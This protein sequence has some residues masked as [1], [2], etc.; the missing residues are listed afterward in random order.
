MLIYV[1]KLYN[2]K[3][4]NLFAGGSGSAEKRLWDWLKLAEDKNFKRIR[5]EEHKDIW[6]SFKKLFGGRS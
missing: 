6:P 3:E 5:I 4:Y 1:G 2:Y